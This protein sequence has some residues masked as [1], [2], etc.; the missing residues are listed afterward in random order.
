MTNP[1]SHLRLPGVIKYFI[2]LKLR[3]QERRLLFKMKQLKVLL[4]SGMLL[5]TDHQ[6]T[7]TIRKAYPH[8]LSERITGNHYSGFKLIKAVA[9]TDIRIRK[10]PI[11]GQ[12]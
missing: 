8:N 6:G 3:S 10:L 1:L 4:P 12:S 2:R 11:I 9:N 7:C 5:R